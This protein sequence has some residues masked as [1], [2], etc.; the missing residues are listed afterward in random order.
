MAEKLLTIQELRALPKTDLQAQ[1][2]TF[3]QELWEHRLKVRAGALQQTH[4]LPLVRRQIA[5]LETVLRG[6]R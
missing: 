1:L 3:R 5:R 6:K 4:L 2:A